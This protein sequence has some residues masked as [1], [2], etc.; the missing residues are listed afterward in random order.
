MCVPYAGAYPAYGPLSTCRRRRCQC[1][2]RVRILGLSTGQPMT[3]PTVNTSIHAHGRGL[4]SLPPKMAANLQ[5]VSHPSQPSE[6]A[7]RVSYPSQSVRSRPRW[8]R[9][10]SA[11]GLGD[12]RRRG[13]WRGGRRT[14]RA[15]RITSPQWPRDE[16]RRLRAGAGRG[17][18]SVRR[19]RDVIRDAT[20]GRGRGARTVTIRVDTSVTLASDPARRRQPPVR[21]MSRFQHASG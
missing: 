9:T 16:P 12:A 4:R 18:R 1:T 20:V 13:W 10:C 7:I 8:R 5:R 15:S 17:A 14:E 21:K 3:R 2:C 19:C 11:G 6:S